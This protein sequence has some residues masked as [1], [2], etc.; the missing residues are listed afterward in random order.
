DHRVVRVRLSAQRPDPDRVRHH[1]RREAV[2][3]SRDLTGAVER[4]LESPG[5]A[6]GFLFLLGAD[7]RLAPFEFNSHSTRPRAT[8]PSQARNGRPVRSCTSSAAGTPSRW[9]RVAVRSAGVTG[10][11][12][13]REPVLS[14]TP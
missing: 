2:L 14:E 7:A 5:E 8:W 11:S 3:H 13:G 6:P 9:S 4:K 10:R 1:H 12:A